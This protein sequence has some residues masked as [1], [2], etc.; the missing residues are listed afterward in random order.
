MKL[1]DSR[2]CTCYTGV[3]KYGKVFLVPVK[4]NATVRS[5]VSS[6]SLAGRRAV[7]A[8]TS[9]RVAKTAAKT[10]IETKAGWVGFDVHPRNF[11]NYSLLIEVYEE[12]HR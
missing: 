9:K 7:V 6:A 1:M 10:H 5:C 11:R 3:T 8:K 2:N 4:A 12:N